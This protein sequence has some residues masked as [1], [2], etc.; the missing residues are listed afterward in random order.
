MND[1]SLR[2]LYVAAESGVVAVFA[3]IGHSARPLGD[4]FL[5]AEAH[6]VAV[7]PRT[8]LVYFPLQGGPQLLIMKPT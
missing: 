4:A 3:E 1:H 8:H 5:A 6:S 2:R 7:D